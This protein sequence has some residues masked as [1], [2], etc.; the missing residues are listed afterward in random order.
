MQPDD[1]DPVQA[2]LGGRVDLYDVAT[3]EVRTRLDALAVRIYAG[4]AALKAKFLILLAATLFLAE[5]AFVGMLV[6]ETPVIGILAVLSVL[7]ALLL[8]AYL[9]YGDPTRREPLDTLSI[10]FLLAIVFA[11]LAALVNSTL[12]PVFT[13]L[14]A[15]GLS[16]FFFLVVGPIEETVKWLAIRAHAYKTD[17]F[18]AVIDGVVYGAVAGLGFATIENTFYIV[19]SVL[20]TAGAGG[21][22]FQFTVQTATQRAFVGPGHVIYSAFA[23]YYLGLAKF[24]SGSRG[25]IVVK[26]LLI[27]VFIHALYNTL[28]S[29]VAFTGPAFVAFVVVYDGFWLGVLF[30][31]VSRYRQYYRQAVAPGPAGD[32][33]ASEE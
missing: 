27:A 16:L 6:V 23:G 13:V 9:W 29:Y 8:A 14:P 25:P 24:N 18:D 30:R 20:A 33:V 5:L 26:G 28:V 32:P 12:F 17:T 21:T 1:R 10:T 19:N 7:P 2:S 4:L 31:K 15:F 3:W 11:T 22:E